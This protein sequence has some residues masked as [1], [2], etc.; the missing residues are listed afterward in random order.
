MAIDVRRTRTEHS[1]ADRSSEDVIRPLL[2][3]TVELLSAASGSIY[4]RQVRRAFGAISRQCPY[5]YD[6]LPTVCGI[7]QLRPS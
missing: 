5:A 1:E 3:E 6:M 4:W 2:K 7:A